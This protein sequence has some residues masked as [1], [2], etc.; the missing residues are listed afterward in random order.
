MTGANKIDRVFTANGCGSNNSSKS[1][2]CMTVDLF[3]DWREELIMRTDDNSKLRV[4]CSTATTKVRLATL[5][6]DMQYRC[7][8]C[9][10]QS[11]YNQP[12]HVSYYLGSDA[13]VPGKPNVQFNNT[14][15]KT[16]IPTTTEPEVTKT[17]TTEP[18]V[19]Q[20][21]V[22][23]P[24]TPASDIVDGQIYTF[25]NVNSGL[26]LD[27][28]GGAAANG[29]NVQQS[30]AAGKQNQFKA[31]AAGDGY[32]YLVSQLG[33]G[34]SYALDVNGKKTADGTNIEIYTFNKGENQKF[35]FVKNDDGTVSIL[36]KIT[37]GKSAIDVNEQS[38]NA[39]ANVQQYTFNGNANQ[40]FTIEAVGA[41]AAEPTTQS[42][43][44]PT[45]EPTTQPTTQSTT[46][47]TQP[48]QTQPV[49]S[50]SQ[51][52]NAIVWGDANCDGKVD[53]S[54]SVLVMQVFSNPSRFGVNGNAEGHI[55]AQ[56]QT[57]ADVSE[58]G[59][60]L[61]TKDALAIQRFCL[62]IIDKLPEA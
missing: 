41:Q 54:D 24:T 1:V 52:Q 18:I 20:P 47:T 10:Q 55:T 13:P 58:N 35:R 8:N 4:W 15:H 6:H 11:S 45:T 62:E 25:K 5:M 44:Q 16:D 3:G 17:P 23:I 12:P 7:Q 59:N 57:N 56:G 31:V 60:G 50:V 29:T 21:P 2:P 14:P 22:D 49:S 51:P 34:E 32:F 28:E 61:T 36:T 30:A 48:I 19:T 33:D 37:D 40:K 27:V 53:M 9:C 43:A 46:Q 26:Y 38:K 39:G 42:T